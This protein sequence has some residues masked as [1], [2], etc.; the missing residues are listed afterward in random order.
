MQR[1]YTHVDYVCRLN[2][3]P[4]ALLQHFLLSCFDTAMSAETAVHGACWCGQVTFSVTGKPMFMG[5]CHC[6]RCR[7]DTSSS[8]VHVVYFTDKQQFT[9]N[10]TASM[11]TSGAVK[12][13]TFGPANMVKTYRCTKCDT[14][15]L[16][17]SEEDDGSH[18]YVTHPSL[19]DFARIGAQETVVRPLPDGWTNQAHIWWKCRLGG[20]EV[21]DGLPHH[22]KHTNSPTMPVTMS[23]ASD[24][25]NSMDTHKAQCRCGNIQWSVTGKPFC[26]QYC[27]CHRCRVAD[28]CRFRVAAVFN[29]D[30]LTTNIDTVDKST[31]IERPVADGFE[32]MTYV[33]CIK[34][35]TK[36]WQLSTKSQKYVLFPS[37]FEFAK[38]NSDNVGAV[39]P[40]AWRPDS[41][42][43]YGA[44]MSGT[45]IDDGLVKYVKGRGGEQ[46]DYKGNP[47]EKA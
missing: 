41:H 22:E 28:T 32:H 43:F 11:V 47:I 21:D 33:R 45:D 20:M 40:D 1:P 14:S 42:I 9:H 35:D 44:R 13:G 3:E 5:I 16:C 26:C 4:Y 29:A 38:G 12:L 7:I 25:L 24:A 37:T 15:V 6:Y 34:C 10:I 36:C 31:C 2:K 46:C 23:K 17:I 19:F 8:G 27:H 39:L 30:Q 18:I